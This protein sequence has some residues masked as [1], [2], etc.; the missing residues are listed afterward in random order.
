MG[1]GGWCI[2]FFS[3]GSFSYTMEQ[4]GPIINSRKMTWT[5]VNMAG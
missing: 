5:G 2:L 3:K 4:V 1:R